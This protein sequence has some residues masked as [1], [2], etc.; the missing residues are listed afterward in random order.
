MDM[1]QKEAQE[2]KLAPGVD[3]V[4]NEGRGDRR[5]EGDF[6]RLSSLMLRSKRGA[7]GPEGTWFA[8]LPNPGCLDSSVHSVC[9]KTGLFCEPLRNVADPR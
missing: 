8:M 2:L 6:W 3:L 5:T 9:K 4:E 7:E 1:I